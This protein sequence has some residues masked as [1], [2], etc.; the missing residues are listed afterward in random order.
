MANLTL[1]IPYS[2]WYDLIM[3]I[4]RVL[5]PGGRLEL[6]D[7]H[8]F[9]PEV[10]YPYETVDNTGI[11]KLSTSTFNGDTMD[12][13]DGLR[14]AS[15]FRSKSLKVRPTPILFNDDDDVFCDTPTTSSPPRKPPTTGPFAEFESKA[16]TA[17]NMEKIF[18][19]MLQEKYRVHPRPHQFLTDLLRKVFGSNNSRKLQSIQVAVPTGDVEVDTSFE[20]EKHH[21]QRPP[22]HEKHR[23]KFSGIGITIEWDKKDKKHS[24]CD[25]PEARPST[26]KDSQNTFPIPALPMEM[27][28]KAAKMLLGSTKKPKSTRPYQPSG[29]IVL[30]STFIP[31]DPEE[32]EMHA[33]KNSNLL[34]NCRYALGI[35]LE[36]RMGKDGLPL[37]SHLDFQELMWEYDWC[38]TISLDS[39]VRT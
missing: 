23:G 8:L 38:V 18:E 29:L 26:S 30:P 12:K 27:T 25:S 21:V 5:K 6:I 10:Q 7:D 24:S 9:F 32:L 19:S 17:R 35:Y 34:L 11:P 33:C 20:S 1:A 14:P 39:R 22:E 37:L 16:R 3:D 31:C 28:P 2:R 36:E 13:V 15:L 4:K